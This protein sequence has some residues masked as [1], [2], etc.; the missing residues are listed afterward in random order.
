[1]D[2]IGLNFFRIILLAV[3][4][5]MVWSYYKKKGLY[6]FK[7]TLGNFGILIGNNLLKPLALGWKFLVFS[8][9]ESFQIFDIPANVYTIILTFFVA[10]FAY[11][12]YHRLNHEIPVLWTL[13]HTHHSS[14]WMNLTT[15]VRLNWLGK[16]VSPVFFIPFVLMGCSP[17]ILVGSLALGLFYQFFL[18]TEAVGRLGFLEGWLLNTPSAHRVHHGSN[19]KYIDKNFGGMLIIYDRL[20]GTYEPETEKVK[21]GV[22]TGFFS[23][24]PIKLNFLPLWQY[25]EGNWRKENK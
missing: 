8:A 25:L 13:H 14:P 12:W 10:E 17:E 6:N 7:E 1:M 15:A 11:Y 16:F 2:S 5:E 9:I 23:H 24:N 18:H 4:V 22:T 20:F 3:L 21:Y 19:K